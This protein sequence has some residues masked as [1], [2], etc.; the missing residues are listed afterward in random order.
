MKMENDT[1]DYPMLEAVNLSKRYEDGVL[2]LD[3]V[4][5]R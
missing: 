2:A 3:H 5:S 4:S 1:I